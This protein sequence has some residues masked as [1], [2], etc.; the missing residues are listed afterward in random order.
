MANFELPNVDASFDNLLFFT[1]ENFPPKA[2]AGMLS[3]LNIWEFFYSLTP[4][5]KKGEWDL[6]SATWKIL[7]TKEKEAFL[8]NWS[9][10]RDKLDINEGK[11]IFFTR[12]RKN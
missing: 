11:N 5:K 7:L 10:L 2:S 3:L 9:S 8:Q 1:D 12:G 4:E 6:S